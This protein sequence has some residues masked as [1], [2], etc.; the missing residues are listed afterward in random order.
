MA[1]NYLKKAEQ[2]KQFY[3]SVLGNP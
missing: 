2:D 1:C 3:L